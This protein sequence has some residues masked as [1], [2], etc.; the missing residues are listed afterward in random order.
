MTNKLS[1]LLLTIPVL[2][3]AQS[4][5]DGQVRTRQ[6][7]DT[8]LIDQRPAAK[9]PAAKPSAI[10]RPPSGAVNGALVGITVWR[11]RPSKPSDGAGVR[12]LIHEDSGDHELTPERVAAST[13]LAEGQKV[14]VSAEAAQEGYLYIIDRDE[15]EDGTKGDPYLI[16][17][18]LKTRG[19]DNHVAPGV[20]LEIPAHD[21]SPPYFEVRRSRPDQTNEVLTF[22]ITPQPLAE[23]NI[24]KGRQKLTNLQVAAWEKQWRTKSQKLEDAAHEGKVYTVTE[25]LAAR[26]E[27]LLSKQDPLPQ[28][29]YRVD[30][31]K[32]DPV[33][34]DLQLRIAK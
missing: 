6:L 12:S 34:L 9:A 13:P 3:A 33:M 7:W 5:S 17:P 8:T 27:K 24:D 1:L 16:F 2:A 31:K 29:M 4:P 14:R 18:T 21:D 15:Y 11:L 23:L 25:K 32:G 30:C 19:G 10:K 28:T 26:G 20:V 22:L